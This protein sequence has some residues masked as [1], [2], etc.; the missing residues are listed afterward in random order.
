MK[1][2]LAIITMSVFLASC[3]N[4]EAY[5]NYSDAQLAIAEDYYEAAKQPLIDLTLPAPDGKEYKL[6]VNREVDPMQI[7]QIKDSEWTAPVQTAI[8]VAGMVGGAAVIINGAGTHTEH[9]GGDYIKGY[10][11]NPTTTTT[12]TEVIQ[13]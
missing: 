12:S 7:Q 13:P 2:L 11:A 8:N 9:I 4:Q 6:V 5:E 10:Q 3:A 1:T